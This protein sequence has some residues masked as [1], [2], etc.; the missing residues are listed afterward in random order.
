ME[1]SEQVRAHYDGYYDGASEWRRV[2]ALGKADNIMR[3]C[4][5]LTVD[6]L[7]DIGC[8]E[9]AVLARLDELGFARAYHAF[10][11]S[12]SGLAALRARGLARLA[13]AEV[14]DGARL[15]AA[16]G[17]Y[18]LA[19][20]SHVV[21]HLE[22]PRG[23]IREAARVARRVFIEVP[24]EDTWLHPRDYVPAPVGHINFFS[25]ANLRRLVQTCGLRVTAQRIAP[26]HPAVAR[27]MNPRFGPLAHAIKATLL[28]LCPAV[29]T[30][31]TC[32]HMA[33]L[34]EPD[35]ARASA[36][37]TRTA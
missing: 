23:L 15:P 21:E 25:P 22:H 3:L 2:G 11:I 7:V 26:P 14:F 16:D 32:Y 17:A 28:A 20:L 34:C 12:S 36:P 13:Q 24:L 6:T 4:R 1:V 18:D 35:P 30:R 8:G 10:D 19:V 29:A 5:G 37:S 27:F 9:G 33:V 31:L